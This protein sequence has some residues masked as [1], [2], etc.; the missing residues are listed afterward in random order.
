MSAT[1]QAESAFAH[2]LVIE[3]GLAIQPPNPLRGLIVPQLHRPESGFRFPLLGLAEHLATCEP[4]SNYLL[5]LFTDEERA[6]LI[7]LFAA[8]IEECW[9]AMN[10]GRRAFRNEAEERVGAVL[11]D[12]MLEELLV[13]VLTC[14]QQRQQQGAEK[15]S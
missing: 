9:I 2:H 7:Y 3:A 11:P 13:E 15:N 10:A 12:P 4:D 5:G 14:V 1:E 8:P 6:E